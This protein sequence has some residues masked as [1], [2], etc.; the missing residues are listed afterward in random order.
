AM[1]LAGGGDPIVSPDGARIAYV[2]QR[3]LYTR[4]LDES[5]VKELFAAQGGTSPFFSP[6]GQWI[7]FFGHGNLRKIS[8]NG[9]QA[10]DICRSTAA[11]AGGSWGEDNHIIAALSA[12]G[13]L[14]RVASAGGEP[15][16]ITTLD[17]ASAEASHR[18]PQILPGGKAVIFTA[19]NSV[20][21]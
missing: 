20:T 10:I 11:Y 3:R 7:A 19:H 1:G 2:S 9:G 4:R 17:S 15:Q 14:W 12:A 5:E 16:A 6:D 8:V 13:P 21:G 18:L